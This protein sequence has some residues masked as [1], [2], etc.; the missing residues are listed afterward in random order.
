MFQKFEVQTHPEPQF[1][2]LLPRFDG[3]AAAE[4]AWIHGATGLATSNFGDFSV[5]VFPVRVER[6]HVQLFEF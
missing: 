4:V 1:A 2:K 6:L 5:G 3:L